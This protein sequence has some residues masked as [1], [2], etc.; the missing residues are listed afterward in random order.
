MNRRTLVLT[1]S[2]LVL[3]AFGAA[4]MLYQPTPTPPAQT[5]TMPPAEPPVR[6]T[7]N[8]VR[9]HSPAF[10]KANAPVTIVEF[11]D[12]S[13]EACRA[14]YPYVKKIL[15]EHPDDVRLVLRYTL[16]H[17]GSEEVARLLEASRKQNL[18]QQVLEAVLEAQPGWHDDP[19]VAKA[20]E[21]AQEVGLDLDKARS[22]MRS[23]GVDAALK[24]DMQDV[25]ALAVQGTPTFFVNGQS[26]NEFSPQA[27]RQLV[28][29]EVAKTKE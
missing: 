26:L 9:F 6:A 18:Y 1:I 2:I 7:A 19:Q 14:F 29:D 15:A 3:A 8:L 20:W 23:A 24:V 13:C 10:G 12:P 22:D 25:K 27:L 28:R 17:Q 16:L 4:V 21:A 5:S 11:F